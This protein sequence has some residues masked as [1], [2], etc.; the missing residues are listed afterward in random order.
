MYNILVYIIQ[1]SGVSEYSNT[2][3]ANVFGDWISF[4]TFFN[5]I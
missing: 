5:N 2:V 3:E 4:V 1:L